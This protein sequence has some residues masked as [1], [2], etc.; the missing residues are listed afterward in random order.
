MPCQVG[1]GGIFLG[2]SLGHSDGLAR[3]YGIHRGNV[4]GLIRGTARSSD[5]SCSVRR[6]LMTV[7]Y[8]CRIGLR[9]TLRRNAGRSR[10][11]RAMFGSPS[12][13]A[14]ATNCGRPTVCISWTC[15]NAVSGS[16]APCIW[17]LKKHV[18]GGE[19]RFAM[20]LT[21][22]PLERSGLATLVRSAIECAS[23]T[24]SAS[25]RYGCARVRTGMKRHATRQRETIF[26]SQ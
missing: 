4:G 13:S 25:L 7:T 24:E 9:P 12:P 2:R 1:F 18:G 19:W 3:S 14:R 5:W 21:P 22:R 10:S 16:P 6:H 26:R 23:G 11:S 17:C 20:R 8:R 15:R